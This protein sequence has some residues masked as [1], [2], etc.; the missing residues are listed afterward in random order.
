MQDAVFIIALISLEQGIACEHVPPNV[1]G[2][3]DLYGQCAQV[4]IVHNQAPTA[5]VPCDNNSVGS[6]QALMESSRISLQNVAEVPHRFV[7][8]ELCKGVE[9]KNGGRTAVKA[10]SCATGVVVGNFPLVSD[11]F[12]EVQIDEVDDQ[13]MGGLRLGL[14]GGDVSEGV[15]AQSLDDLVN[16]KEDLIYIDGST[17]KKNGNALQLSHAPPSYVMRV[18]DKFHL[19]HSADG[20]LHLGINEEEFEAA[21]CDLPAKM[22]PVVELLGSVRS[23]SVTSNSH[24]IT[25]SFRKN[26]NNAV[27]DDSLNISV[28]Q[29]LSETLTWEFHDN[30][31]K[32]IVLSK[33]RRTATRTKSFDQGIV[34]SG[35]PLVCNE[36][37][38]VSIDCLDQ[39]SWDSSLVIGI[40]STNPDKLSLPRTALG[41]N[42]VLFVCG[43]V[44]V[45]NQFRQ[46]LLADSLN[47]LKQ[48]QCLG[49]CLDSHNDLHLLINGSDQ[50][51]IARDVRAPCHAFVDLY[52]QCRQVS[53]V[54]NSSGGPATLSNQVKLRNKEKTDDTGTEDLSFTVVTEECRYL[55]LCSRVASS[56]GLPRVFLDISSAVCFCSTCFR[57]RG[58]SDRTKKGDPPRILATPQGWVKFSVGPSSAIPTNWHTAY[59]GTRLNLVRKIL[60][61]GKLCPEG[62][63]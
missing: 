27:Q 15:L 7:I 63:L 11:S 46:A 5:M 41:F 40:L 58:E 59:H 50:G 39:D 53:I 32:N 1:Y 3:I 16:R 45:R 33:N 56:M 14:V 61:Y 36:P 38:C 44:V 48:G 20:E 21:V 35:R 43:D 52:G 4:S 29:K 17:V 23:I 34:L 18:G 49:L 54:T 31:G 26:K 24:H 2:V 22:W 47:S 57:L 25:T 12:F 60:D 51:V 8:S 42:N 28:P 9:V 55:R 13:L 30:H 6:S 62:M 10:S 19:R 37:F